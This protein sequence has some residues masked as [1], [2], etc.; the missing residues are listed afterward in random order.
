MT[1]AEKIKYGLILLGAIALA[2]ILITLV[3]ALRKSAETNY[4][5]LIDSRDREI[6]A[7]QGQRDILL[8]WNASSSAGAQTHCLQSGSNKLL[9]NMKKFL[10]LS[11]LLLMLNC[12]GQSLTDTIIKLPSKVAR[13]LYTDALQKDILLEQVAILNQ[14][15][16]QKEAILDFMQDKDSVTGLVI[17]T[18]Q[19]EIEVMKG[20]RSILQAQIIALNKSLVR[21]KRKTFWVSVAGI[22]STIG[23]IFLFK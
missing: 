16:A 23:A 7:I 9:S 11:M 19:D 18:Y 13:Q 1:T 17:R 21:Q 3:T 6:K 15:I 4:E 8:Q 22:A 5:L 12:S 2:V 14:R 20:T 10:L